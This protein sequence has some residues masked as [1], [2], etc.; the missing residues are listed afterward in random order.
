MPF[1]CPAEGCQSNWENLK[2]VMEGGKKDISA[3][4]RFTVVVC[5]PRH[6]L[7]FSCTHFKEAL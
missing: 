5:F 7:S 6:P 2:T 4:T 3:A 1:W